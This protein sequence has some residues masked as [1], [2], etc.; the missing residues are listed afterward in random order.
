M[1]NVTLKTGEI[2]TCE[3]KTDVREEIDK[4]NE[5][6]LLQAFDLYCVG[7]P[8]EV[9]VKQLKECV[10]G[11]HK[12]LELEEDARFF[13]SNQVRYFLEKLETV[14]ISKLARKRITEI[15]KES[16]LEGSEY[17]S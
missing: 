7:D 11:Y 2:I 15:L 8:Q 14:E 5:P 12:D 16:E 17:L 9:E 13:L 6:D 3:N 1:I 4:L 10:D